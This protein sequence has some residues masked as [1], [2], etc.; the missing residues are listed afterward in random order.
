M[1]ILPDK[2]DAPLIV[3]ANAVLAPSAAM[4]S[5]QVIARRRSKVTQFNRSVELTK[6]AAS[7]SLDVAESRNSL[8][9]M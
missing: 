3:H 6:F 5:L 9:V 4:Q 1:T 8:T 2:T 7:D